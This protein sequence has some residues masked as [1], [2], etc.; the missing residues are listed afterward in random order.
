MAKPIQF[1]R[2]R[3][4]ERAMHLFWRQGYHGTSISDLE[5]ATGLLRGSLYNTFGSKDDLYLEA[6]DCYEQHVIAPRL[7]RLD[8]QDPAGSVRR[9]F[10]AMVE[11][12]T[13]PKQPSGCLFTHAS[14]SVE[15]LPRSIQRR[16]GMAVASQE[17]ALE[18]ALRA[19]QRAQRLTPAVD[20]RALARALLALIQGMGVL[21]SVSLDRG[22]L[23]DAASSAVHMIE[24]ETA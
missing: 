23:Q 19:A 6:L 20:A 11:R 5:E 17:R 4:L 15:S 24:R 13:D 18:D 21:S 7:A 3:A 2:A 14:T 12:M 16:I 1:D 10:D 8:P 22:I 9:M